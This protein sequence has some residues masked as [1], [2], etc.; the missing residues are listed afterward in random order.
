MA[1]AAIQAIP[2]TYNRINFRSRAEARWALFFDLVGIKYQYEPEKCFTG[3]FR[4]IPDFILTLQDDGGEVWFEVKGRAASL[5]D[6]SKLANI[7]HQSGIPAFIAS[8]ALTENDIQ[9]VWMEGQ[10]I[11]YAPACFWGCILC[12][13]IVPE[14]TLGNEYKGVP[15]AHRCFN[16]AYVAYCAGVSIEFVRSDHPWIAAVSQESAIATV[17]LEYAQNVQF[18]G[19]NIHEKLAEQQK[20][21]E[22][23]IEEGCTVRSAQMYFLMNILQDRKRGLG[24]ECD[25]KKCIAIM[26]E[27]LP[28]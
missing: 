7:A 17:A 9:K 21:F 15:P 28:D 14:S 8:G 16:E 4:Y 26:R 25:Q 23:L 27:R 24:G 10:D 5:A 22:R 18:E 19:K 12:G 6:M 3:A 20:V 1:T 11:K 13:A 2:T